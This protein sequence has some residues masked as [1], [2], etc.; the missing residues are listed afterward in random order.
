[1]AVGRRLCG[2]R[3]ALYVHVVAAPALAFLASAIHKLIAPGFD[4]L[5]RAAVVTGLVITLYTVVV[6]P[7]IERFYAMFRS[8]IG[9]WLPFA[10]I[11][12]ASWAAG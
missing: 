9:T 8:L 12:L 7:I 10:A 4:S 11:F 6:A 5:L 3:T 2:L 1:M